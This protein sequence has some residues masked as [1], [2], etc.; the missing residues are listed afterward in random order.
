M[1]A[2]QESPM[3]LSTETAAHELRKLMARLYPDPSPYAHRSPPKRKRPK[4]TSLQ[5]LVQTNASLD[6]LLLHTVALRENAVVKAVLHREDMLEQAVAVVAKTRPLALSEL[7]SLQQRCCDA[8]VDVLLAI[9]DWRDALAAMHSHGRVFIWR[10]VSYIHKLTTDVP[11]I[12]KLVADDVSN[13]FFLPCT[14]E[15]LLVKR[16]DG[17][18]DDDGIQ[19]HRSSQDTACRH[20]RL[21]DAA[22]VLLHDA[23]FIE[24]W[25][26]MTQPHRRQPRQ[27][28]GNPLPDVILNHPFLSQLRASQ[29]D[30]LQ[31]GVP[32]KGYSLLTQALALLHIDVAMDP[33]ALLLV[34]R[35]IQGADIPSPVV[36]KL[37]RFMTTHASL[38]PARL[39]H[40]S[41]TAARVSL[42]L[43][44][45]LV[46]AARHCCTSLYSNDLA[47]TVARPRRIRLGMRRGLLV[48]VDDSNRVHVT[49]KRFN[50]TTSALHHT[51]LSHHD[52]LAHFTSMD[53]CHQPTRLNL[54]TLGALFDACNLDW[55]KQVLAADSSNPM[56]TSCLV[57]IVVGN[58]LGMQLKPLGSMDVWPTST[59]AQAR[60]FLDRHHAVA[61]PRQY[62]FLY[63]GSVCPVSQ[64]SWR[65]IL[66]ARAVSATTTPPLVVC[67]LDKN[68][69][70]TDRHVIRA[71]AE[72]M[73]AHLL[74]IPIHMALEEKR[75]RD[76]Q[77]RLDALA[78]MPRPKTSMM[79]Y[80]EVD[81]P[82]FEPTAMKLPF[83]PTRTLR[84]VMS[85][86]AVQ[87]QV[88]LDTTSH[89]IYM[90]MQLVQDDTKLVHVSCGV[91]GLP[92]LRFV[93]KRVDVILACVVPFHVEHGSSI[94]RP[95]MW[96]AT[97]ET[98]PFDHWTLLPGHVLVFGAD[99]FTIVSIHSDH[100][101]RRRPVLTLDR[102][103]LGPTACFVTCQKA[104]LQRLTDPRLPWEAH[105]QV[106]AYVARHRT[107]QKGRAFRKATSVPAA[108]RH[109]RQHIALI[110]IHLRA[111]SVDWFVDFLYDTLSNAFPASIGVTANKFAAFLKA[112]DLASRVQATTPKAALA[113]FEQFLDARHPVLLKPHFRI[114]LTA[115]ASLVHP[116]LF[117]HDEICDD[118]VHVAG[119]CTDASLT[120]PTTGLDDG[121]TLAPP[122]AADSTTGGELDRN[123]RITAWHTHR[124]LYAHILSNAPPQVQDSILSHVVEMALD[125]EI[126][127]QCAAQLVQSLVRM[128]FH[129]HRFVA[130]RK[131][132]IGVQAWYRAIYYRRRYLAD[133]DVR[134][135]IARERAE[136]KAAV[137]LLLYLRRRVLARR[138]ALREA[139]R[140]QLEAELA[141]LATDYR[142]FQ[143]GRQSRTQRR[144]RAQAHS[145]ALLNRRTNMF[146][147][148][149][150]Q[151][152]AAT[153]YMR[154]LTVYEPQ[155]SKTHVLPLAP[156][157]QATLEWSTH[158]VARLVPRLELRSAETLRLSMK[159]HATRQ[160][161]R[162]LCL[163]RALPVANLPQRVQLPTARFVVE[164]FQYTD[165]IMLQVYNPTNSHIWRRSLHL[166][167]SSGTTALLEV[168]ASLRVVPL[169]P[170]TSTANHG[171]EIHTQDELQDLVQSHV[172]IEIQRHVRRRL[173]TQVAK[174]LAVTQ[175]LRVQVKN[176]YQYVH[177]LSGT[178]RET[179]PPLLRDAVPANAM[180]EWIFVRNDTHTRVLSSYFI[181]PRKA[182]ISTKSHAQ[183]AAFIQTWYRN[184]G[185][186]RN[187]PD[188]V[189]TIVCLAKFHWRWQVDAS[190]QEA[191]R[192]H[193]HLLYDA[194]WVHLVHCDVA[195]AG[196]L[197]EYAF[198]L[199]THHPTSSTPAELAL[200]V[201]C[202]CVFW[203]STDASA[204]WRRRAL[205]L[206]GQHRP[207]LI[208][209]LA[210]D[211]QHHFYEWALLH[212][213]AA[214]TVVHAHGV[215]LL[216]IYG[217]ATAAQARFAEALAFGASRDVVALNQ[218]LA[219]SFTT[220]AVFVDTISLDEYALA[221][222]ATDDHVRLNPV[223]VLQERF[224]H[225][226]RYY[227]RYR[228]AADAATA[229]E[230]HRLV[231][232]DERQQG[233][234]IATTQP[235]C[236][237][238]S[239]MRALTHVL[240]VH[241]I[242]HD[243][244]RATALYG[245]AD[246][247][248]LR[249][250]PLFHCGHALLLLVLN[251]VASTTRA[252][253]LLA[254]HPCRTPQLVWLELVF[255]R[256]AVVVNP[257]DA[258]ALCNLALFYQCVKK[259]LHVAETLFRM[260]VALPQ[261]A[262]FALALQL[263]FR[264]QKHRLPSSVSSGLGPTTAVL[265]DKTTRTL[266]KLGPWCRLCYLVQQTYPIY[267][268][269]NVVSSQCVWERHVLR[270]R[271]VPDDVQAAVT[272]VLQAHAVV[273]LQS[274]TRHWLAT[275]FFLHHQQFPSIKLSPP[276]APTGHASSSSSDVTPDILLALD[277]QFLH[278]AWKQAQ[279]VYI[280]VLDTSPWHAL[281][282]GGLMLLHLVQGHDD[283][284]QKYHHRFHK[285]ESHPRGDSPSALLVKWSLYALT[286][287]PLT[288]WWRWL[289]AALALQCIA[290]DFDEAEV[291]FDRLRASPWGSLPLVVQ[292]RDAFLARRERGN[293]Y[294]GI[295]P[296]LARCREADVCSLP[297]LVAAQREPRWQL[298]QCRAPH[299]PAFFWRHRVTQKCQWRLPDALASSTVHNAA[300]R[301]LQNHMRRWSVACIQWTR[302]GLLSNAGITTATVHAWFCQVESA[303]V[304]DGPSPP[305]ATHG[306]A[307][308]LGPIPAHVLSL[309]LRH[310]NLE[311]SRAALVDPLD[312]VSYCVAALVHWLDINTIDQGHACH[313]KMQTLVAA[314]SDSG[315]NATTT[316]WTAVVLALLRYAIVLDPSSPFALLRLALHAHYLQPNVRLAHQLYR[317]AHVA[318]ADVSAAKDLVDHHWRVLDRMEPSLMSKRSLRTPDTTVPATAPSPWERK[319]V[320]P[321]R[322]IWYNPCTERV[323]V[324]CP[325]WLHRMPIVCSNCDDVVCRLQ[326]WLKQRGRP[327][328]HVAASHSKLHRRVVWLYHNEPTT[329]ESMTAPAVSCT[330][331]ACLRLALRRWCMQLDLRGGWHILVKAHPRFPHDAAILQ[332]VALLTMVAKRDIHDPH[333]MRQ[334]HQAV[335]GHTGLT[336]IVLD[337]LHWMLLLDPASNGNN[338]DVH[339]QVRL[340][341]ALAE[342]YVEKDVIK[343]H[344]HFLR[345]Y[346][347]DLTGD[348]R[349]MVEH[350]LSYYHDAVR[351][352]G[353]STRMLREATPLLASTRNGSPWQRLSLHRWHHPK[354]IYVHV[355]SGKAFWATP[356]VT[357]ART[358]KTM[359]AATVLQTFWTTHG[360]LWRRVRRLYAVSIIRP[361]L[362]ALFAT[363]QPT[364]PLESIL[365][366]HL[367]QGERTTAK[368]KYTAILDQ[369]PTNSTALKALALCLLATPPLD[370]MPPEAFNL[371]ERAAGIPLC[372]SS[373]GTPPPAPRLGFYCAY[374]ILTKSLDPLAVLHMALVAEYIEPNLA[375]A[376]QC[377]SWASRQDM[378]LL[379]L[380]AMR[381]HMQCLPL[382]FH[383]THDGPGELVRQ[384]A[385]ELDRHRTA[386]NWHLYLDVA[387]AAPSL[388]LF[389]YNTSTTCT[390]W[391]LPRWAFDRIKYPPDATQHVSVLQRF[392]HR[393]IA[394][395]KP[396]PWGLASLVRA[397]KYHATV[398]AKY[399]KDR[400]RPAAVTN[401]A[402]H[403]HT[404]QNNVK[405]AKDLYKEALAV[406][407]HHVLSCCYALYLLAV[408]QPPRLHSARD[409]E[410]RLAA[411]KQSVP[412]LQEDFAVAHDNFFRYAITAFPDASWA[413]LNYA[414]LLE[415]IY[416]EYDKADHIYRHGLAVEAKEATRTMGGAVAANNQSSFLN[417]NYE[418][419]RVKCAKDGAHNLRGPLHRVYVASTCIWSAGTWKLMRM[420]A[421]EMAF[422]Q[423]KQ[424]PSA[425]T[426]WHN[427]ITCKSYWAP[428]PDTLLPQ[429]AHVPRV[430]VWVH[431]HWFHRVARHVFRLQT[432]LRRCIARRVGT[433]LVNL[434]PARAWAT[435]QMLATPTD[436]D[437][438]VVAH[439]I[440]MDAAKAA[441]LYRRVLTTAPKH[442]NAAWCLAI[443]L[444]SLGRA[445]E[446]AALLQ[447]KSSQGF[448]AL[449]SSQRRLSSQGSRDGVVS[450]KASMMRRQTTVVASMANRLTKSSGNMAARPPMMKTSTRDAAQDGQAD[451][452]VIDDDAATR[453]LV[454]SDSFRH[455]AK[456]VLLDELA[457]VFQFQVVREP[458]NATAWVQ[459]ALVQQYGFQNHAVAAY[460][461]RRAA[462][463]AAVHGSTIPSKIMVNLRQTLYNEQWE[464]VMSTSGPGEVARRA[465]TL[466][467]QCNEWQYRECADEAM[468][469]CRRFW[470]NVQTC[471]T[472]W[473][474]PL[475]VDESVVASLDN[476]R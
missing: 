110:L 154:W 315:G 425:S 276:A 47:T 93:H 94:V 328:N 148:V 341:L 101:A 233:T 170:P 335:Q 136:F 462:R 426:F 34:L 122:G 287:D 420:D 66:P 200:V 3:S 196:A 424:V 295:A 198:R 181:F 461:L 72:T 402:L 458:A 242:E 135:A 465:S 211:I 11:A 49:L 281:A 248:G 212:H 474:P 61:C 362:G 27:A 79:I 26:N 441:D 262:H 429:Y 365:Y 451:S 57:A 257:H 116:Q 23:E 431:D 119:G 123:T 256:H 375:L 259:D 309:L 325:R 415:C 367:V 201:V 220:T 329:I 88:K 194:L 432:W 216:T 86:V 288:L 374:A 433:I 222:R 324:A 45:L 134:D 410:A 437:H 419:F 164:V 294:M 132:T 6:P 342:L 291:V 411:A 273:V 444:H 152:H 91:D 153:S 52:Y 12:K 85:F 373:S 4:P 207:K 232:R 265:V 33:R 428:R 475:E 445:A 258:L 339:T 321:A 161:K 230:I 439:A 190:H 77:A 250:H 205:S 320:E 139:A 231:P 95:C 409:A 140:R 310:N 185:H 406:S 340:V 455:A 356:D 89:D 372:S 53:D 327:A 454:S 32:P 199:Y 323:V 368:A 305:S 29:I 386:A 422:L 111:L 182:W 476:M 41:T 235:S 17:G 90:A 317:R 473:M 195:K 127:R 83:D 58:R 330:A 383:P 159:E 448:R 118:A 297:R 13:P 369:D 360:S 302:R 442:V 16:D 213:P 447:A 22:A 42:W 43:L 385:T 225:N 64:E 261:H 157:T 108:L 272:D 18:D 471:R 347:N 78:R 146:L 162:L 252:V 126:H 209:A 236:P 147:R 97:D 404:F 395:K 470:Y 277:L 268:W 68:E 275:R 150:V 270:Q 129:R 337:C 46:A 1:Q 266:V 163:S 106:E 392:Y 180:R 359:H 166:H 334:L 14:L 208:M 175:W 417:E 396:Y 318:A 389:W 313:R 361:S 102:A 210:I 299:A 73:L 343:A 247:T 255:V 311:A 412:R 421:A 349:D 354:Q 172:V 218:M 269:Y 74:Y 203:L 401:F 238:M 355:P 237:P 253:R 70:A 96:W 69:R 67:S 54:T 403:V 113:F 283:L 304:E 124:F 103:Y 370:H 112:Y 44:H 36:V 263:A 59:L 332:L 408:C 114:A 104:M 387:A 174:Y 457:L 239:I 125:L 155:T 249:D 452:H 398:T 251:G 440:Q 179:K 399:A 312:A 459:Y 293:I 39:Y 188:C 226:R 183:A 284:F 346:S 98:P 115:I 35:T 379:A 348:Y 131:Q 171:Y 219:T 371:L 244:N 469:H 438:A 345:A 51:H 202:C 186:S 289:Q 331:E 20:T 285:L 298:F 141:A 316:T 31:R 229:A 243:H 99:R 336:S 227:L 177:S 413:W 71:K 466:L 363:N 167:G 307:S 30:S 308:A 456:K 414:L 215:F 65:R 364:T 156:A 217:R 75:R 271:N 197:Y 145:A 138:V 467:C 282:T 376:R 430:F 443:L 418:S 151:V 191:S 435:I 204:V 121:R 9:R 7:Q 2:K 394:V 130:R 169:P 82:R 221:V 254:T 352:L 338:R 107:R 319:C 184:R 48:S 55:T 405:K 60:T 21:L 407:D 468:D 28:N 76:E 133:K 214:A 228:H 80:L 300:A 143:A 384:R 264:F 109:L 10:G 192:I 378:H 81:V 260:A 353:P 453:C 393:H 388:M 25:R 173:A 382:G 358:A 117:P 436:F 400:S 472:Q 278:G 366:L 463:V 8:T 267:F 24:L 149:F 446:A 38:R 15:S 176:R 168:I 87:H 449:S 306:I 165:E 333:A 423:T 224:R 434:E 120:T 303:V 92:H 223:V 137:V 245:K 206:L 63:R 391:T 187:F 357:L 292:H 390:Y 100:L 158:D 50:V 397:L 377:Y 128:R 344:G 40:E 460:L 178:W 279:A 5:P 427:T 464:D 142:A 241:F 350:F 240:H 160:G 381:F 189:R 286:C 246:V 450:E 84:D 234:S 351:T 105:A 19:R 296:A 314:E 62:R 274:W 290:H 280:R 380:P 193:M 37:T 56:T 144:W 301:I 322:F 416:A 326:R